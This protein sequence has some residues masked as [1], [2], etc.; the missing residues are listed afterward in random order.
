MAPN[1]PMGAKRT[2]RP[3]MRKN[4]WPAASIA[5]AMRSPVGPMCDTAIPL[6][7]AT[8]RTCSR[9]PLA[10]ASKKLLGTM[11]SRCAVTLSCLAAVT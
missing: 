4:I 9:S 8:S 6:R 2:I 7:I 10:K 11:A 3:M 1:A 5:A